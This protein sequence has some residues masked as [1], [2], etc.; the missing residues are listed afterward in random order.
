MLIALT[1]FDCGETMK[2]YIEMLYPTLAA[3]A[4]TL[5][6]IGCKGSGGI[7]HAPK[8]PGVSDPLL[9]SQKLG[10]SPYSAPV[11]NESK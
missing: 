1:G 6:I 5:L 3:F 7:T 11:S 4:L 9:V 8:D 2:I 10:N